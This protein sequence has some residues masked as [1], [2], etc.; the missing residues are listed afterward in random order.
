MQRSL[1]G[2]QESFTQTFIGVAPNGIASVSRS[3]EQAAEEDDEFPGKQQDM[4]QTE[5]RDFFRRAP[6]QRATKAI[7]KSRVSK[8]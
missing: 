3:L 4:L 6:L 7:A 1:V 8:K 2:T 5:I